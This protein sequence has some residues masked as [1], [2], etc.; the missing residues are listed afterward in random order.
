MSVQ[1]LQQFV[2]EPRCGIWALAAATSLFLVRLVQ[3]LLSSSTIPKRIP[4]I[5][6]K[7]EQWLFPLTRARFRNIFNL[8]ACLASMYKNHKDETSILPVLG[9]GDLVFVPIRE[10]QWLADQPDTI[11]SSHELFVD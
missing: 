2:T 8:K 4:I 3:A 11:A 7:S 5:G 10:I 9:I 1:Q 6:V